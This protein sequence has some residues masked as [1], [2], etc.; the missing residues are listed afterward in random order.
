VNL[1]ADSVILGIRK[2]E[3]SVGIY[4]AAYNIYMGL[5]QFGMAI[6]SAAFPV[7]ARANF[8]SSKEGRIVFRTAAM[9]LVF[10]GIILAIALTAFSSKIILF[11]YGPVFSQSSTPLAILSWAFI[12]ISLNRLCT[13]AL[14][15]IG[16]QLQAFFLTTFTA[17]SN[18]LANII[19][20]PRF[21]YIGASWVTLLTELILFIISFFNLQW[22]WKKESNSRK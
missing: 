3:Y 6:V 17:I 11:I 22:I 16:H 21:G 7:I 4:N 2:G 18:I 20:I 13:N 5:F 1:R 15:A 14:G 12:F 9:F 19:I 10:P 8:R